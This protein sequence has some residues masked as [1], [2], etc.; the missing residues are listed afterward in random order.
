MQSSVETLQDTY[1]SWDLPSQ[2]EYLA[3][4]ELQF[5]LQFL[6]PEGSLAK[7][8]TVG[9][10]YTKDFAY[11]PNTLFSIYVPPDHDYAIGSTQYVSLWELNPGESVSLPCRLTLDRSDVILG[12]F[13]FEMEG[14]T[15]I[16]GVD[17][18]IWS[19]S[20]ELV[21]PVPA[22][23]SIVDIATMVIAL[24]LTGYVAYTALEEAK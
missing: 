14:D 2:V 21:S 7:Y 23:V 6:A 19:V 10:L 1:L 15:P 22:Y 11:I 8:Y 16:I 4:Q 12:L 9:A 20:T 13:L 24:A 5:T 3:G 18:E 17:E